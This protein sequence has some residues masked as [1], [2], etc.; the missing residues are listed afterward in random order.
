MGWRTPDRPESLRGKKDD[1]FWFTLFHEIG[2][3]LLHSTGG[4]YVLGSDD[5]AE[6]EADRF[7]AD[8]LIPPTLAKELP[9][10]RNSQ[11]VVDFA[12]RAGIAPGIVVG[13]VQ[14]ESGDYGWGHRLKVD[15][16]FVAV[17]ER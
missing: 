2:H 3:V 10:A 15:I 9:R 16:D 7:A 4:L 11:A 13:R 1:R 5:T 14:R 12:R 6:N 8:T 17:E